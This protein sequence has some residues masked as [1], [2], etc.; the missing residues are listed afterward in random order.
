MHR[1]AG[2]THF[3]ENTAVFGEKTGRPYYVAGGVCDDERF[4]APNDNTL[5]VNGLISCVGSQTCR[6][7]RRIIGIYCCHCGKSNPVLI[8]I[9][10]TPNDAVDFRPSGNNS[11]TIRTLK[12][13]TIN[14]PL[15]IFYYSQLIST[16]CRSGVVC[17]PDSHTGS[18]WF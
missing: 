3:T 16:L 10:F 18:P 14:I 1:G 5:A 13:N 8:H 11:T 6:H 17:P 7:L 4:T 15:L 12:G 2:R 9:V